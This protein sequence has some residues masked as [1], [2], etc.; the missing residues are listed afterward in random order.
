MQGFKKTAV[1]VAVGLS[2][3]A[4]VAMAAPTGPDLSA[5]TGAV[6]LGTVTAGILAVQ[7]LKIVPK[8]ARWASSMISGMFGRG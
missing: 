1:A 2:V 3:A 6:L 7:A 4:P 5:L 8:I